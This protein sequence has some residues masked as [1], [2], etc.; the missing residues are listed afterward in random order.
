MSKNV[1]VPIANIDTEPAK[2]SLKDLR[3]EIKDLK[4]QMVN[5]EEG[6]D[7]FLEAANKAG[8]LKHQI[9]EINES[10]KGASSDFGDMI[11]N[12]TNVA[13][14]LTGAFQAVAGGLQALG[15]ESKA[16][17][18][19]IKR[20]QGL[21]AV[22][23][24]LS[25]IDD[26][27]KSFKKLEKSIQG[28]TAA[29]KAFKAISNP[30]ALA[31]VAAIIV[32]IGAAWNK[33][34]EDIRKSVPWVDNLIKKFDGTASAEIERMA[35]KQ[36]L[37]R[38]ELEKSNT[39]ASQ[40]LKDR[41]LAELTP[42]AISKITEYERDLVLVENELLRIQERLNNVGNNRTEWERIRAEA[43]AVYARQTEINN[44]INDLYTNPKYKKANQDSIKA[45][46][47]RAAAAERE[48]IAQERKAKNGMAIGGTVVPLQVKPASEQ[49]L[50]PI[51][52]AMGKTIA[53]AEIKARNQEWKDRMQEIEDAG[54]SLFEGIRE[55]MGAFSDSSLGLT[56]GWIA[57]LDQFQKAFQD[58]MKIVKDE[59]S[60]SWESY[61]GVAATALGG[62]G[63][64]LNALS[65]EQDVS[66]KEGFEQQKKLQISATVMN[67]LSGIMAAWTSSMALPAPA[68]FIT[69]AVQTAATAALGAAQIAKIKAQ[70]MDSA[71][72]S[73]AINA[74]PSA[75]ASTIIPP[76]QYSAAVQG[77]QTEGAIK[78]TKVYVTESDITNTVNK[79]SVQENENTW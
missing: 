61:A 4:D 71:I 58:T 44:S 23:Q 20:M 68:S 75:I 34:G 16:I 47:E 36:K 50:R 54:N 17:D 53:D 32:A 64:M 1:N 66:T 74:S 72:A 60:V 6:S 77:A 38:E 7:A 14:G 51:G 78:N 55:S 65:Q 3:K 69:G 27:I 42:E 22:T 37:F 25:A 46:E 10:V 12:I 11:G 43:D 48:R 8:E 21:M 49:D 70:T 39:A 33:W 31:A 52:E 45:A 30:V 26:G 35:E 56:S 62:I 29:M 28:S 19:T 59:G 9:D 41:R 2:K 76:V 79:V 18:E 15:L 63:T 13:A 24:G 40:I 73:G 67:M 5:L 57:S